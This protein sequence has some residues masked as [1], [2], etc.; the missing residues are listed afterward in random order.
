M[1]WEVDSQM[2]TQNLD[3]YLKLHMFNVST[4]KRTNETVD[5]DQIYVQVTS[6]RVCVI[7][8]KN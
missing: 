8:K 3:L 7:Q 6:T 5:L 2:D 4:T 1:L